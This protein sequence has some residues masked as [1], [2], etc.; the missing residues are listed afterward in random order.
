MTVTV[1]V[2]A[3]GDARQIGQQVARAMR[4]RPEPPKRSRVPWQRHELFRE[5]A[6]DPA[7]SFGLEDEDDAG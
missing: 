5:P 4:R 2:N 3:A 6:Y 7:V 1:N